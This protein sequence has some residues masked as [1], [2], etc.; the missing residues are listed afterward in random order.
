MEA[1]VD[2]SLTRA[3]V[4]VTSSTFE[5]GRMEFGLVT[6]TDEVGTLVVMREDASGSGENVPIRIEA[7]IGRFGDAPRES[8]LLE[9]ITKRLEQ[10]RGRDVAPIAW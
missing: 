3:E 2:V 5:L 6:A 9:A 4:A 8:R 7:H 10:L 1:A